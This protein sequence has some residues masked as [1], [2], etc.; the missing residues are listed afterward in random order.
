MLHGTERGFWIVHSRKVSDLNL[1]SSRLV[2][3]KSA[4]MLSVISGLK[5]LS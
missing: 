1:E 5:V 2:F 4:F 3:K